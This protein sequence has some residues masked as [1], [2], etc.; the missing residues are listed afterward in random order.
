MVGFLT[1]I[2]QSMDTNTPEPLLN[3]E[4]FDRMLTRP[5]LEDGTQG[6]YGLGFY[7]LNQPPD[8]DQLHSFHHFGNNQGFSSYMGADVEGT[9][10]L[11]IMCN[12]NSVTLDPLRREL[13]RQILEI[14]DSTEQM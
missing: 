12:R 14:I 13:M 1:H 9:F 7:V 3:Q 5:V 8:S 11:A 6:S 4:N 10:A 2:Q